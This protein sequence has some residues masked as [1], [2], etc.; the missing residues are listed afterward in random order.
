MS[1]RAN[2]ATID[3]LEEGNIIDRRVARTLNSEEAEALSIDLN[4][5]KFPV[6]FV[7]GPMLQHRAVLVFRGGFSEDILG[8]DLAYIKGKLRDITKIQSCKA[9]E[10]DENAQYTANIVN[11][12]LKKAHKVL[13]AHPINEDRKRRGLLPANYLLIKGPGI[14]VPKL[15][16]YPRWAAVSYMSLEKGFAELSGMKVFSFDYPLFNE[17]DAYGNLWDGLKKA[18]NFSI[19]FIKKSVKDFDYIYIH[20]N[21]TDF[22]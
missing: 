13:D 20:I 15:K 3:S 11:E 19:K 21:E 17:L 4:K 14:E 7:F 18:C 8:N 16:K 10:D 2:F 22:D 5:I 6:D 1:F 12:F 9:L